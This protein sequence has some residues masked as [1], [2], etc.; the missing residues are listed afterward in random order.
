MENL[1]DQL[2]EM[3]GQNCYTVSQDIPARV[4]ADAHGVTVN[5][6]SGGELFIPRA[7][8]ETA[9]GRLVRQRSLRV[10]E[11][12]REITDEAGPI[13][14]RLMAVLRMLP[15]VEVKTRRPRELVYRW[16][17]Y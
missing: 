13:T 6:Q 7:I 1:Y 9:I 16:P 15:S 8:V 4:K 11:V 12:H 5:Y 3:S 17:G 14:D 10:K 2:I